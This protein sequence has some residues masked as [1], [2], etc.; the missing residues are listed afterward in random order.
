AAQLGLLRAPDRGRGNVLVDAGLKADVVFVK[1]AL[2][3]DEL[4]VE[5]A[6]RGAAIAGDIAC[7]VEAGAAVAL[8][9]PQAQPHDGPEAGDQDPA[10]REVEFVVER[11]L[12][13][14]HRASLRGQCA[15]ATK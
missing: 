11:D 14:R 7:G 4:L 1:R 10:L 15:L 13:E 12:V 3:A 2:R 6:Q 9:L 5:G 8:L